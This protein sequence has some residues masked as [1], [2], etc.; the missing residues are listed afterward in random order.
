MSIAIPDVIVNLNFEN[1]DNVTHML[2]GGLT[3]LLGD[4]LDADDDGVLDAVYWTELVDAVG[5]VEL[6]F[7]GEVLDLLYTDTLLGPIGTYPP[8]HV[9]RCPDGGDWVLGVFASLL[10]DTPG[11]PNMCD[12]PDFDG[13]GVFDLVDNCFLPNPDQVDCNDNGIGDVC[14]I[15][16]GFSLDCNANGISDECEEDCDGNGIPDECD[17]AGGADD[18][19]GNGVLDSCEEDCNDN[20]I[21]DACDISSGFSLDDNG[22]GVP[23]ECEVG[24]LVYTSFEEPLIGD[25]YYDL[26]DAALDH[27]LVNNDGEAMVEWVASGAEMGFTAWYVNTRDGVGLTDGDYVGVTNYTSGGVGS[28]PDGE[29]GY[30]LSD[31]DGLMRVDFDT[32][33]GSGEWNVSLEMFVA[34]T[35]WESEDVIVVDVVVDGGVV[36]PLLDTTGQDINDLGIEGAWFNLLQDLSGYTQATLRISLDSNAGTEAIFMDS[37]VFS[38]NAIQDTD[39]DGIPDSQDNCYL[40]NPDQLDCNG[41]GVGDVCDLADG[42]SFDCNLND[43]PDECEPDCNTNGIPDE[44]DIAD[45]TSED[46]DGDGTPDYCEV[47]CDGDGVPDDCDWV[48]FADCDGDGTIDACEVDVNDDWIPDDCQCIADVSGDGMV[49]VEDILLLLVLWGKQIDPHEETLDE[50]LNADG[51]IDIADILIVILAWG[52]CSP[53]TIPNIT[54]ACCLTQFWCDDLTEVAC[55][56]R[57]GTYMGDDTTCNDDLCSN[58]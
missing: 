25:K 1:A 58:P 41:N 34:A 43:V 48:I 46:C 57:L 50:D 30:Q 49:A 13:D 18:C 17:L 45:G 28:Y 23:D 51:I 5:L 52:E 47:D 32:A 22:N 33:T 11:E 29:Q 2:V 19:D 15:D 20:G 39:G 42:V 7:E 44:C 36:L 31:C 35:T 53:F 27:Q 54:G 55:G 26:G 56:V 37:V 14:D 4:D 24:T 9:F 21:V 6:G 16:S 3:A 8:S 40:P 10:M 12:V 38:S